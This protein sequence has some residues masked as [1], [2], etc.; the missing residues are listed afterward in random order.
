MIGDNSNI[1]YDGLSYLVDNTEL[2]ELYVTSILLGSLTKFKHHRL[3]KIYKTKYHVY[4][5]VRN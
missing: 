2:T 3:E 5:A 4:T 1:T